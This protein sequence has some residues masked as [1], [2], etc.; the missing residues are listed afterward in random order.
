M[1]DI[2]AV[3]I[4]KS[5]QPCEA[6]T[7]IEEHQSDT[8]LKEAIREH[9]KYIVCGKGN[10][11]QF[12][13]SQSL[14]RYETRCLQICLVIGLPASTALEQFSVQCRKT[15]TKNITLTNHNRR[16]Q[17]SEPIGTQSRYM[18]PAPSTGKRVFWFWFYF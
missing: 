2:R 6:D 8:L 5:G 12:P 10:V 3:H 14:K 9:T 18:E 13:L 16:R 1:Y 7:P 15:K 4:S 11:V 17:S